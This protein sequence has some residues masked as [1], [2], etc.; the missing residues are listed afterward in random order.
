LHS[1]V[2]LA[3]AGEIVWRTTQTP[4]LTMR[5]FSGAFLDGYLARGGAALLG[6]VGC[7][8]LEGEGA[9]LFQRIE[10][11]SFAILGLPLMPLLQALRTKG[12]LAS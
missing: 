10:G 12:A 6:S 1:A 9:Q 11:D 2:A 7:Y 4:R 5:R 3:E 8:L